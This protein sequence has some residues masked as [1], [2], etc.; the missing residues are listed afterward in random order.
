VPAG[1][2]LS[3]PGEWPPGPG[4]KPG[5]RPGAAQPAPPNYSGPPATAAHDPGIAPQPGNPYAYPQ[6]GNPYAQP[7]N[8]YAYPQPRDP[9]AYPQPGEPGQR[10]PG[11]MTAAAV[12]GYI[13]GGLL[14]IAAMIVLTGA[15]LVA[16]IDNAATTVDLERFT[17]ELTLDGFLN[18]VAAGLLIAGGVAITRR[19]PVGRTMYSIG[20]AIVLVEAVYWLVRWDSQIDDA[21]GLAFYAALFGVLAVIGLFLVWTRIGSAWLLGAPPQPYGS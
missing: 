11:T 2:P 7:T 12:L 18:V 8:P 10:R 5:E 15:S 1:Q 21:S 19:R 20:A 13:S 4:E 9:Y 17:V 6:P 3:S 16:S 14:V